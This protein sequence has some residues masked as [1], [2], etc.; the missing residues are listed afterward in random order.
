VGS[1]ASPARRTRLNKSSSR[2]LLLLCL[3]RT[4]QRRAACESIAFSSHGKGNSNGTL[5]CPHDRLRPRSLQTCTGRRAGQ[6]PNDPQSRGGYGDIAGARPELHRHIR[7]GSRRFCESKFPIRSRCEKSVLHSSTKNRFA[8][9]SAK[10]RHG[11]S[12][13]QV[14]VV[15][16]VEVAAR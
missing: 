12:C 11:G 5:P 14:F 3:A 4:A 9:I 7:Q 15:V 1:L 2:S 6:V 8:T 13:H 16:L 10:K